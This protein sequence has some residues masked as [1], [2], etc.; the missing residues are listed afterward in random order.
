MWTTLEL[1]PPLLTT[2][3][4]Q[5]KDVSALDRFNVHHITA[6]MEKIILERLTYYLNSNDLLSIEQYG[7]KRGHSTADQILYFGQ[8]V[9]DSQN[10]RPSH[11]TVAV[12]LD[13]SKAFDRV[14]R[15][16]LIIK[17]FNTFGIRDTEP[18]LGFSTF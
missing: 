14:W 18:Y 5:R 8:R 12:F 16:K 4:H 10:L 7:F 2:T 13:L 9:R 15:N 6:L 17:L 3:P 1:A 11:H